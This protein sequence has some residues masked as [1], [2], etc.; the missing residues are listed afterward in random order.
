MKNHCHFT[1][2]YRGA[3]H[4]KCNLET[5]TLNF[6]PVYF[7]NLSGYDAHIFIKYLGKSAG[8]IECIPN[9]EEKYISYSNNIWVGEKKK[10]YKI[11]FL[12]TFLWPQV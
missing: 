11:R 1:D 6:T 5:K 12:D 7:H 3:A 9:N 10:Y 2:E 4:N 8:K